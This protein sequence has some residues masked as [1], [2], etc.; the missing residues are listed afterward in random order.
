[1]MGKIK[2]SGKKRVPEDTREKE[3]RGNWVPVRDSGIHI[4]SRMK[5]DPKEAD[6]V[7]GESQKHNGG[8]GPAAPPSGLMV[9]LTEAVH[10]KFEDVS[11]LSSPLSLLIVKVKI[12]ASIRLQKFPNTRMVRRTVMY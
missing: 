7:K 8:F 5:R 3:G 9:F 4:P 1:M 6:S 2:K 11:L 12:V 10:S